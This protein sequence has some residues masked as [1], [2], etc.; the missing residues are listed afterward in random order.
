MESRKSPRE[1]SNSPKKKYRQPRLTVYGSI[2]ELTT[3]GS[4]HAMEGSKGK[5]ARP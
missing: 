3:G 1:G 4:G 2:G 5:N